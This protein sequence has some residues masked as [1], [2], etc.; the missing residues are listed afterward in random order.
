MHRGERKSTSYGAGGIKSNV[1]G[2]GSDQFDKSTPKD[3]K[4]MVYFFNRFYLC[5]SG[6]SVF[7]VTVMVYIQDNVGIRDHRSEPMQKKKVAIPGGGVVGFGKKRGPNSC[8]NVPTADLGSVPADVPFASFP[9]PLYRFPA[10]G[11]QS[12]EYEDGKSI[13]KPPEMN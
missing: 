13:W 2:F 10:V 5:I 1:A 11:L 6:G 4:A 12:E 7:A 9:S 8:E 3:E